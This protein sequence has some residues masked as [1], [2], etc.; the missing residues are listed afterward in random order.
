MKL[1]KILVLFI[2]TVLCCTALAS[3]GDNDLDTGVF[4]VTTSSD[5]AIAKR[6]LDGKERNDQVYVIK[7]GEQSNSY[8]NIL[9][10]YYQDPSEYQDERSFYKNTADIAPFKAGSRT[11]EG[12]SFSLFGSSQACLTA[13]EGDALWV[14]NFTLEQGGKKFS[15]EDKDVKDILSS[16]KLK[17]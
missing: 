5:W 10:C 3:C 8:P 16:L 13:K 1:K 9:I 14:C 7:G 11:W 4:T 12:Y 15:I 6:K 2:I 17:K